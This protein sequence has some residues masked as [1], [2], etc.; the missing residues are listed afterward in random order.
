MIRLDGGI[1]FQ[2]SCHREEGGVPGVEFQQAL[3]LG[4][5][6]PGSAGLTED[7][8]Q[9]QTRADFGG[10]K[11]DGLLDPVDGLGVMPLLREA[12][13]PG[14]GGRGIAGISGGFFIVFQGFGVAVGVVE[15]DG[16]VVLSGDRSGIE[17]HGVPKEI[18]GLGRFA[19][20]GVQAAEDGKRRHV[21]R[22]ERKRA[23][24]NG[25]TARRPSGKETRMSER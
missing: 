23:A 6:F 24:V 16:E 9:V 12:T 8:G 10:T 5:G 3:H 20:F 22:V 11:V 19:G 7:V 21:V 2:V 17:A 18:L 4:K 25:P 13:T 15:K 1:L 14:V